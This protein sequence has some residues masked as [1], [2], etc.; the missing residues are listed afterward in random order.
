MMQVSGVLQT[1]V[2]L[3]DRVCRMRWGVCWWKLSL[4]GCTCGGWGCTERLS[5]CPAGRLEQPLSS[6]TSNLALSCEKSGL[7]T[8]RVWGGIGSCIIMVLYIWVCCVT[9]P[10]C[11]FD[12]A[13]FFLFR[14]KEERCKQGQ[15]NNKTKQHVHGGLQYKQS[16]YNSYTLRPRDIREIINPRARL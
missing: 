5:R 11:F 13:C 6:C 2:S 14:R 1:A 9:L 15:T 3:A 10:C 7:F 4:W 12:L 16:T 8:G